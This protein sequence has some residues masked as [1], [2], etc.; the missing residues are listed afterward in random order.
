MRFLGEGLHTDLADL[1]Q[2]PHEHPAAGLGD[3][4]L[5]LE[6]DLRLTKFGLLTQAVGLSLDLAIIH[7]SYAAAYS[8]RPLHP[9]HW[10]PGRPARQPRRWPS[11][12]PAPQP[13]P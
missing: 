2:P 7:P 5:E 6:S 10:R 3:Q 11:R 9:S 1:Q 12:S 4:F 13:R 8:G